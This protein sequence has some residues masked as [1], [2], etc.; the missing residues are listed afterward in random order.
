DSLSLMEFKNEIDVQIA[1]KMLKHPLLRSWNL[2]LSREFDMTNDRA[3]FRKESNLFRL[4]E[5]KMIHQFT[6][7]FNSPR[8]WIDGTGQRALITQE[9]RRVEKA[10]EKLATE[11]GF[12]SKTKTIHERANAYLASS[13]LESVTP[14]DVHIDA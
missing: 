14:A 6:H 2:T 5:G 1:Q 4:Y 8:Y 3:F 9:I 10:V 12:L 13:G 11:Q 7:L